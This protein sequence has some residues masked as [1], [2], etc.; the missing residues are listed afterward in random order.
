V[1]EFVAAL[2]PKGKVFPATWVN[3]DSSELT[4]NDWRRSLASYRASLP[5]P[6]LIK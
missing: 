5:A 2:T 6:F 3:Q 1:N 4:Y